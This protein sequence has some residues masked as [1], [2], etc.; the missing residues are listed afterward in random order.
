[1]EILAP[2]FLEYWAVRR[3]LPHARASWT[4]VRLA[5]WKGASQGSIVVVCGL[6]GA[7]APG[8]S[9]GTVL[10]PD[11]IGLADGRIVYCDSALVQALVAAARTLHFRP[12]TRPLLTSQS[13]ITGG[14]RH[15]WSQRGFVAA[16]METGLLA[17]QN[18]RVATIRVVLDSPEHGISPDWLQPTRVLLQPPLWRELFWLSRVA[19]RYALRAARVLKVG[20]GTGPGSMFAE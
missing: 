10:I 15:D 18:L 16:D 8:L 3:T 20:L 12:D 7:L 17:G 9:P 1:M 6:A 19:P 5:R 2:T 11:Q 13:L 14:D 4:G